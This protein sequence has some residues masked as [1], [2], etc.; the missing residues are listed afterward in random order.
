MKLSIAAAA[1]LA[2]TTL[3][4]LSVGA[5]PE[6]KDNFAGTW[7]LQIPHSSIRSNFKETMTVGYKDGFQEYQTVVDN[8]GKKSGKRY[9]AKPDGQPYAYYDV[10]TG[11]KRGMMRMT[12]TRPWM[13]ITSFVEDDPSIPGPAGIE[14][15]LSNDGHTL[16][17][18][19][20]NKEGAITN[21]LSWD[22]Q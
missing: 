13:E 19:L 3:A 20:K 14:H 7:I 2:L 16:F 21:I 12:Q 15:W 6:D 5:A 11:K 8:N 1:L 4:P 17:S 9:R 22:R 18:V 10:V